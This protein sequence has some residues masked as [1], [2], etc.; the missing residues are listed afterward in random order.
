M[1]MWLE[2]IIVFSGFWFSGSWTNSLIICCAA[3]TWKAMISSPVGIIS[4]GGKKNPKFPV[5]LNSMEYAYGMP[6]SPKA[7]S[8]ELP[9]DVMFRRHGIHPT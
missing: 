2:D 1:L 7:Q 5:S 6:A 9:P 3:E 4:V 8:G